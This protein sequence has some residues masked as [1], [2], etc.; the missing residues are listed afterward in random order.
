MRVA[1]IDLGTNTFNLL[2]A[3]VGESNFQVVHNS[4]EGVALG[5]GGINEQRI[6]PEAMTRAL[7]AFEKFA[8]I[9][10][11]HEVRNVRAIG[12]SA[13]RDATNADELVDAVRKSYGVTIEVIDGLQEAQL[14]YDGV[15]WSYD[16]TEPSLIMDIGGGSTEFIRGHQDEELQFCSLNIGV[17]RAVQLFDVSDPLTP[18]D[19]QTLVSWFEENAGELAGFKACTTLVGASGSFETF[20][21]MINETRFPE[22]IMPIWLNRTELEET[23]DWIIRSTFEERERHPHIIPIRRRMAPIA[24][25]K[26]RWILHKFDINEIVISPCSLK[27]GTLR[28]VIFD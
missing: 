11:R 22:G 8:G 10:S 17:S 6:A 28:S 5:M 9:C 20:Y 19:Q 14:I 3:D 18:E 23:L 15:R 16:F 13:L 2:I 26:T 25:L 4:K 24:A 21:E 7:A 27:E 1:V 12:T